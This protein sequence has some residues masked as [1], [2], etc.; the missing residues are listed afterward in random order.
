MRTEV[1]V[2][3]RCPAYSAIGDASRAARPVAKRLPQGS[4]KIS[5]P[6]T[7]PLVSTPAGRGPLRRDGANHPAR[8]AF[9]VSHHPDSLLHQWWCELVASHYRPWGSPGFCPL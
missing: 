8:S 1:R 4:S 6:S 2:A 3:R 9:V 5:S 7:W